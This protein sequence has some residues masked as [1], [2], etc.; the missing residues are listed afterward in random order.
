MGLLD[1]KYT[2]PK[3]EFWINFIGYI[4]IPPT[5]YML[6]LVLKIFFEFM[7]DVILLDFVIMFIASM[8]SNLLISAL[9]IRRL[10]DTGKSARFA[11]LSSIPIADLFLIHFYLKESAPVPADE[12][13]HKLLLVISSLVREAFYYPIIFLLVELIAISIG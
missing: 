8:A 13:E 2:T 3:T 1:T 9:I 11:L 12:S 10:K 4:C 6:Y 7:D 5:I